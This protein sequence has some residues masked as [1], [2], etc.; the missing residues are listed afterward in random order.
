MILGRWEVLSVV[1]LI[2][3]IGAA[4]GAC[5]FNSSELRVTMSELHPVIKA[6]I[7]GTEV[8]FIVDSGAFY[9]FLSPSAASRSKLALSRPPAS[10]VLTGAGAR[11]VDMR[12]TIVQDLRLD[13][14]AYKNA[15]FLIAPMVD[16]GGILGQNILNAGDA[17]YDL[18]DGVIRLGHSEGCEGLP[19]AYWASAGRAYSVIA[20]Q[21]SDTAGAQTIGSALLNGIEVSV[22]FDTGSATSLVSLGAAKRA[23]VTPQSRGVVDAGYSL[24]SARHPFRTWI[25]PF[26]SFKIGEEELP[27]PRLRMGDIGAPIDMLL[28][29][30]FFSSHRIYVANGR[31]KIYFT[32]NG[33]PVFN[34]SPNAARYSPGQR[35]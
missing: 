17:E 24:G 30:D 3:P 22:G 33:G 18:A 9:S 19:L 10:V 15:G 31:R 1:L 8:S 23:G 32:Y 28:G 25:A 20:I 34:A 11:N 5:K 29:A 16:R 35:N 27:A 4:V 26:A 13:G 21:S 14:A 12:W 6:Q 7:N 2:A